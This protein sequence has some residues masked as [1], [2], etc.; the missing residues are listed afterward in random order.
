MNQT[1]NYKLSQ[2]AMTDRI[3]MKD[4]NTDNAKL[5]S[6]LSSLASK[7]ANLDAAVAAAKKE[8]RAEL[9]AEAARL[10]TAKPQWADLM[11]VA[12]PGDGTQMKNFPV[13][14]LGLEDCLLF[15]VEYILS[16]SFSCGLRVLDDFHNQELTK[17]P[18]GRM[19]Q[20]LF[21]PMKNPDAYASCLPLG[22]LSGR[23]VTVIT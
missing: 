20:A 6:A 15:V 5:E 11:N 19:Y 9:A 8:L 1:K 18:G 3:L 4:F 12:W 13:S 14:G 10:D 16:S 2:W 17:S 22:T 21:L 7:D 23:S